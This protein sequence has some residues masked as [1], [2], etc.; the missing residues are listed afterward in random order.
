MSTVHH[1]TRLITAGARQKSGT[2]G[3]QPV[4]GEK[5]MKT[6]EDVTLFT[7]A[8]PTK[9]FCCYFRWR[10]NRRHFEGSKKCCP[11]QLA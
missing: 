10:C 6:E 1:F 8:L 3:R 4:D 2:N 9:P 11:A 7:H 5:E